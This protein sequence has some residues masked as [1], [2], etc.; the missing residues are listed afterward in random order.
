MSDAFRI[1]YVPAAVADLE[2]VRAY[3]RGRILQT[4][5]RHLRHEP[6]RESKSAIKRMQQPFWS[7]FR[8]RA[9]DFRVYYD[10]DE[11][12]RQVIVLRILNK[13]SGST[14]QEPT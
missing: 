8:L 4:I 13:G 9:G 3:D 5:D 6:T 14:P 1:D 10:V 7:Q 2:A 11:A 12:A